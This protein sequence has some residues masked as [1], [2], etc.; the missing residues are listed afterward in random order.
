LKVLANESSTAGH[1]G[2]FEAARR[3]VRWLAKA[4]FE[5]VKGVLFKAAG[6]VNKA[7]ACRGFAAAGNEQLPAT[8]PAQSAACAVT[9]AWGKPQLSGPMHWTQ[10]HTGL[11]SFLALTAR[12]W[13]EGSA[14]A[15]RKIDNKVSAG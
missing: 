11:C 5:A 3:T 12:L 7:G 13:F 4:H 14:D 8:E 9:V 1:H 10:F 2:Q 15:R 6:T